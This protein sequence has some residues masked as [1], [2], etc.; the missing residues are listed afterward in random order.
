MTDYVFTT[1]IGSPIDPRNLTRHCHA[2]TEKAGLGHGG[3]HAL[4]HSA[5]TIMLSMGVPLEV[6]SRT[7]GHA[8]YAITADIYAHVGSDLQR[9]AADAM[10]RALSS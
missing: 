4:R 2:L 8:R 7:R 3:F 1:P 5:A 10:D 6:I 9:R